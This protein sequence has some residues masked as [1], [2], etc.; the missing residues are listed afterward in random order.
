[1]NLYSWPIQA[2]EA[3]GY[4]HSKNVVHCDIGAHNFLIQDDGS[5]ALSDF[6]GSS[7][8]G[9]ES[10]VAPSVRYARP[11]S[12]AERL[13]RVNEKDD[14]F[15]LSTILYEISVGHRL[16]AEKSDNDVYELLQKHDFPDL[17]GL[18]AR[19]RTAIERCWKGEYNSVEEIKSDL[20]E[21][22]ANLKPLDH[23]STSLNLLRWFGF[24]SGMLLVLIVFLKGK[25]TL[26]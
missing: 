16:D 4:I 2:V 25:R 18:D 23:H 7:I 21:Y 10:A 3:V 20:S 26:K 8:D 9:S 13:L 1:M 14:M 19:L 24:S 22:T 15:G 17:F 11:L 12:L 5:L 6:C